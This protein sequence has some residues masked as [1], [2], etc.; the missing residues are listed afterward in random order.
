MSGVQGPYRHLPPSVGR[1]PAE[2]EL[3]A[4]IESAGFRDVRCRILTGGI[5]VLHWGGKPEAA[6]CTRRR[7]RIGQR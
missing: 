2:N 1:I 6:Q 3:A 7:T 5:A 4:V